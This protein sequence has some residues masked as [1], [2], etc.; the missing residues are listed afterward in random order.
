M[1]LSIL[2]QPK[3]R[4]REYETQIRREYEWVPVTTFA[5]KRAEILESFLAR[6]RIYTNEYFFSK[7]EQRARQN[8]RDSIRILR[9]T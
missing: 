3:E 4:F 1:D 2:G 5:A 9:A 8:L 7:Y 6:E